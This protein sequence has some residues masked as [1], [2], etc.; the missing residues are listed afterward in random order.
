MWDLLGLFSSS[1]APVQLLFLLLYKSFILTFITIFMT[2]YSYIIA[3]F[4]TFT[5]PN[6]TPDE[7]STSKSTRKKK[8]PSCRISHSQHTFGI[9]GPHCQGKPDSRSNSPVDNEFR[10]SDTIL[11]AEDRRGESFTTNA[12]T[13]HFYKENLELLKNQ[14]RELLNSIEQEEKQLLAEIATRKE[15]IKR[16]QASRATAPLPAPSHSSPDD[17]LPPDTT[18][19]PA[20]LPSSLATTFAPN[21]TMSTLL[22]RPFFDQQQ[23][24]GNSAFAPSAVPT[25]RA[26][27]AV[28]GLFTTA[29]G[30]ASRPGIPGLQPVPVTSVAAFD[31]PAPAVNQNELFLRPTRANHI[32]KGKTLRIVDF[33]SRIRPSEDEKVLSY[34]DNCKLTLTLQDS[35]PKLSS[36]TIEQFNIANLRIFHELIFSGKITTLLDIQDYLSYSIKVLEMA[37]KYTWESVL[38]YDDEFRILQHTYGFSWGTDHSHLHEVVLMPRWV[39]KLSRGS[40]HSSTSPYSSSDMG[41]KGSSNFVSHL[42]NG[43][44]ICRLFN[45]RKG[46]Q[47]SPCKFSH[48]CNRK[49]GSQA[50]GKTHQGYLHPTGGL[51]DGTQK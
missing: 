29:P 19:S 43:S 44:E 3:L 46:C 9:P 17:I 34:D 49:V 22:R 28:L 7:S 31:R 15:S 4:L 24:S 13:V 47:K 48:A 25:Q 30:F 51:G 33:V 20:I 14:E 5:T 21:D 23:Q 2:M 37:T 12:A 1:L 11:A 32:T 39:A 8:Y 41:N 18:V 36:V 45:S 38:L 26:A 16:L 42:P 35:K 50:C 6:S 40:G 27:A 10:S